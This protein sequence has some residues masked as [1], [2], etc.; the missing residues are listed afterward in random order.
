MGVCVYA[1]NLSY[2]RKKIYKVYAFKRAVTKVQK[3]PKLIIVDVTH[4]YTVS[5][6][7]KTPLYRVQS[8][9][10][11]AMFFIDFFCI[12]YAECPPYFYFRLV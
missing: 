1:C 2:L 4:I 3:L 9:G 8:F 5:Q 10:D 11:F 7:N 6:K 12:L